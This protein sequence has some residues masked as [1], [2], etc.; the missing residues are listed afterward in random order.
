MLCFKE[1]LFFKGLCVFIWEKKSTKSALF[2]FHILGEQIVSEYT[3][4][5]F[6]KGKWV[7]ES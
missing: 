7:E 3:V 4:V 1:H 6:Q 5:N 2:K